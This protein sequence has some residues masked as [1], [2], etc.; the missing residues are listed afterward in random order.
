MADPHGY[1]TEEV[2]LSPV[3]KAALD[4]LVLP[5]GEHITIH[6]VHLNHLDLVWYWRFPDTLEMCL[7]TIRW[8]VDLLEEH[9]DARYS[10]TQVFSLRVV[11]LLDPTLFERFR[12]LV[13]EG[14]IEIDSGQVVEPDHNLPSGES[15]ARQF[16]YGQRFIETRFGTRSSTLVNSDSFGHARSLPQLMRL[17]GI[18]HMIFKRPRQKYVDL[19]E[20][21]FLWKGIDGTTIPALRFINKGIGLPSLSQ[22][23]VLPD[24]VTELQEKVNRNL[25]VGVHHF[26][27]SHC[28]SDAGG[29]TPYV[30]P[31]VGEGYELKYD[32]PS[33]F[34]DALLQEGIS[35]PVT[36]RPLN[37]TYQGCYTTHIEQK[38]Q[39]RRSERELR[40]VEFLWTLC[41]LLGYGYPRSQIAAC[42]R[43]LCFLQFHD[44]LP[45]TGSHEAHLDCNAIYHE[46]FLDAAVLRRKAQLL[47]DRC[48]AKSDSIRSFL[49]ANPR[50]HK[51]GGIAVADVDMPV[52]REVSG[53]DL[54]PDS[55]VLEDSQG[56]RMPYQIIAQRRYQRYVRGTMIFPID[57]VPS[58]GVKSVRM[59]ESETPDQYVIA[60]N[61]ILENQFLRVQV[62]GP[63]IVQSIKTKNDGREWLRSGDSSVRLELWPETEY[64]LDYRSSMKAWQ[65]GVTDYFEVAE[66]VAGPVIIEH[67]PVRVTSR[68]EHRWNNSRFITDVSLYADRDFIEFRFELDWHEKEVLTRFC[69]EPDLTGEL[70]RRYGIPFGTEIATGDEKEVPVVG[71]ADLSGDDGGVAVLNIDRPGHSFRDSAIRVS[72][73]RC[74]TGDHD[75][76]TDAGVIRTVLRVV[77]HFGTFEEA[78]IPSKS[79][80]FTHPLIAWQVEP[81]RDFIVHESPVTLDGQ[82]VVLSSVKVTEDGDGFLLRAYETLGRQCRADFVINSDVVKC[83][84]AEGN[85]LEDEISPIEV[86]DGRA[87]VS[88][89]PYEIKTILLKLDKPIDDISAKANTGLFAW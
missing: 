13:K 42:W 54:I 17:A 68:M 6:M 31:F 29:V 57:N 38:E 41:A 44:I 55:G 71:W 72:L 20:H 26:F 79:D 30:Q 48:C 32:T 1:E 63:G 8:H 7:E 74:A 75:P 67:G 50:S 66:Y 53:G 10:H 33:T 36:E 4:S 12:A 70:F 73:V 64:E 82:G 58:I 84:V 88:F 21:P 14:R 89:R 37:Y 40:Q 69:I 22:Y 24:G 62:G 59:V 15:L 81:R 65:L 11:E 86:V 76:C 19:P 49:V 47:L 35:L 83:Q 46:L 87:Y 2:Q 85:V 61:S 23:Y 34:F 28:N 3:H 52:S 77:P 18:K 25:A 78:L 56:S 60:T 9:P 80:E 43:R 39:C 51:S 5:E 45:G 27:G 16:L